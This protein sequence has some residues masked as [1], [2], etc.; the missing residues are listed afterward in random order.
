MIKITPFELFFLVI[1]YNLVV[2]KSG[3][4]NKLVISFL[5]S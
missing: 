2:V 4:P 3:K 5:A 1:Y